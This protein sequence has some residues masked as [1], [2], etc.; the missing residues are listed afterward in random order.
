M[1]SE[2][3]KEK[4]GSFDQPCL[5]DAAKHRLVVE[6]IRQFGEVRLRVTGTSM[7]PAVWPG[8]ILTVHRRDAAELSPGQIVLCYRE[9]GFVAHRLVGKHAG[10]LITRGD[11]LPYEDPPFREDEILGQVVTVL[12]NGRSVDPSRNWWSSAASWIL[13]RSDLCARLTLRLR[14]R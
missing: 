9:Q 7:L 1:L 6:L 3:L 4:M 5:R 2:R 12:R 8:D 11:C 13:R 10:H 14:T